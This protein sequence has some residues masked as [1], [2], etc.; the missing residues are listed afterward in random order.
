MTVGY[1]LNPSANKRKALNKF[2]Y[3]NRKQINLLTS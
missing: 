3:F 1:S 2:V